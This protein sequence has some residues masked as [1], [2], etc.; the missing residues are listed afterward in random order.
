[1]MSRL[2]RSVIIR[3]AAFM[4]HVVHPSTARNSDVYASL[5][6]RKYRCAGY[7]LRRKGRST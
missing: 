7:Q 4:K 5:S 2:Y 1:M 6:S 3:Y